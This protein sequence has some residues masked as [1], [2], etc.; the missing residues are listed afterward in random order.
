MFMT[1]ASNQKYELTTFRKANLLRLKKYMNEVLLDQLP[2]LTPMLRGFEEMALMADNNIKS[3]SSFI[4]EVLPEL[5]AK[6]VNGRNWKEIAK[7]QIVNYFSPD[8][9]QAKEDM[10]RMMKLYTSEVFEDFME[11]PKCGECGQLAT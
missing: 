11:D 8:A 7:F 5:R 3:G 2:I 4:V 9:K 1:Q 6:I 10:E